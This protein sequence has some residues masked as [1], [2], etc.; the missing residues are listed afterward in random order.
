[1]DFLLR[2]L[3]SSLEKAVIS[4]KKEILFETKNFQPDA[5]APTV[6]KSVKD[7]LLQLV[8]NSV[9]HGIEAPEERVADGKTR[10]GHI[11]LTSEMCDGRLVVTLEDNGRGID[12]E[13]V[14]D[15]MLHQKRVTPEALSAMSE[16]D[17]LR[18]IF[19]AGIST[20]EG[21]SEFAGRGMGMSIVSE[22]ARQI[23]A[24]IAVESVKG[25]FTRFIITL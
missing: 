6:R 4:Q 7:M 16:G 3:K 18:L 11:V 5:I 20:H 19:A 23:G 14:A 2:S 17:R 24:E 10:E 9:I 8:R 22:N 13:K 25:R 21:V 15:Q 12:I 1:M